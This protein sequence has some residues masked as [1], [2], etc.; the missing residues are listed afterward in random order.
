MRTEKELEAFLKVAPYYAV[1]KPVENAQ[2]ITA[3]IQNII[4]DDFRVEL[5]TFEELTLANTAPKWRAN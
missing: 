1:I 5:P 4:G 2:T 3:R